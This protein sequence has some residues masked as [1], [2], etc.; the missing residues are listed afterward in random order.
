MFPSL[1]LPL[2]PTTRPV[3]TTDPVSTP[4]TTQSLAC[5]LLFA[6]HG[7]EVLATIGTKPQL[8][9]VVD[10]GQATLQLLRSL[11]NRLSRPS[12]HQKSL[13]HQMAVFSH[14]CEVLCD[15]VEG[16]KHRTTKTLLM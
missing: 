16:D 10:A 14:L 7:S 9:L 15:L 8:L 4:E 1:V 13:K 6:L 11:L 12:K 2:M 3:R 5:L